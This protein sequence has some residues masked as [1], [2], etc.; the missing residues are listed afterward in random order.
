MEITYAPKGILQI[1]NAR[2]CFR[3]FRGEAAKYNRE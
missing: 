2:I 1:D 3:N